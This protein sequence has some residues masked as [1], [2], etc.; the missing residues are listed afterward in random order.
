MNTIFSSG[1]YKEFN[2]T[3]SIQSITL[4]PGK[5]KL[6]VWGAQGGNGGLGGYSSGQIDI[7]VETKVYIYVGGAGSYGVGGWNGGGGT[8]TGGSY[9]GGG[10]T[11]IR[12]NSN[13]STRIIVAGGGGGM[14][15]SSGY[16]GAGGGLIGGTGSGSG[17]Y[18]EAYGGT[19]TS[20]GATSSNRGSF[21]STNGSFGQGGIGFG[22]SGG[23]GGGGWYG[24][25]GATHGGG[26][27]G[28]GYVGN[29]IDGVTYNGIRSGNGYAKITC[30]SSYIKKKNSNIYRDTNYP[31]VFNFDKISLF[32]NYIIKK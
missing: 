23:G 22:N 4:N 11:D 32:D 21:Y 8:S 20:G 17:S 13:L 29:L 10:A 2:Y 24:G 5:Y 9:G 1:K 27:G 3:N 30:I 25:G 12:E 19:Q 16:G 6:E 7:I 18:G 31:S 26:A 15:H 28:S 14:G